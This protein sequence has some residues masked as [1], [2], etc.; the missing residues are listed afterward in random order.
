MR[1]QATGTQTSARQGNAADAAR[2]IHAI[3]DGVRLAPE[4]YFW[5]HR[6]FKVRPPGAASL[7]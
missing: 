7:Y 5:V 1:E 4:Q 6:R 3:E 2:V